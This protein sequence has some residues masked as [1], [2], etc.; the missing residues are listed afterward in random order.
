MSDDDEDTDEFE[1]FDSAEA[2]IAHHMADLEP[3][4]W[5]ELHA[6][7]CPVTLRAVD[8]CRCQPLRLV[9]QEPS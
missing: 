5:I 8:D 1:R 9:K 4:D 7:H 6:E 3:G 2:M